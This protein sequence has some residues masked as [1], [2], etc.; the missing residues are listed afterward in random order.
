M[1]TLA[2]ALD[3]RLVKPGA[4]DLNSD[5]ALPDRKRGQ[6]GVWVVTGAGVLSLLASG[7]IVW[8]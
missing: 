7:V 4:Y 6:H 8:L 1:A 2:V 3:V 5:A